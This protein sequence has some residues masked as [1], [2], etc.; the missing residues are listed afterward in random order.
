MKFRDIFYLLIIVLSP[1]LAYS[2]AGGT[3][4]IIKSTTAGGGGTASGASITVT[5]SMGEAVSGTSSSGGIFSV[6]SG[7][8]PP[9]PQAVPTA[10][11]VTVSGRVLTASGSGIRNAVVTLIDTR[12]VVRSVSTSSFGYYHFED[13]RAGGSYV[14][15]VA[16]KRF[17]FSPQAVNL[18]DNLTDLNLV[19]EP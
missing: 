3:F 2:Q 5:S 18:T 9:P 17:R 6:G 4:V 12:G 15:G 13:V 11:N 8:Q 10:A 1:T 7:F 14:I 19:A 16:S